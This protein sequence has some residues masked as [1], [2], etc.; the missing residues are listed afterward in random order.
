MANIRK[1]L[2]D[3]LIADA[4]ITALVSTYKSAPA[5]FNMEHVPHDAK[6]PFIW[7]MPGFNDTDWSTKNAPGRFAEGNIGVYADN[8]G[9]SAVIDD[10]SEKIINRFRRATITVAGFKSVIV[11]AN[12]PVPAETDKQ[13]VGRIINVRAGLKQS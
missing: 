11:S 3:H 6:A 5:I 8:K 7:I 1:A 13:T 10:L 2:Y 12:G 4:G 9:S